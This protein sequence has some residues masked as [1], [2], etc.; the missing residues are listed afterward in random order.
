ML[1]PLASTVHESTG[2]RVVHLDYR[3]L[4]TARWTAHG[5]GDLDESTYILVLVNDVNDSV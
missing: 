2:E 4:G 5:L 3:C 1:W